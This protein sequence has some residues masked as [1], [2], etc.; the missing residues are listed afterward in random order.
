MKKLLIGSLMAL[1]FMAYT[2]CSTSGHSAKSEKCGASGKCGG[3]KSMKKCAEG[4]CGGAK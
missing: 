1:S 3:D 2:G 4:K